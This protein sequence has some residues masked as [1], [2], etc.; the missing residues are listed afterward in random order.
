MAQTV[1]QQT[2][3]CQTKNHQLRSPRKVNFPENFHT[4]FA[5]CTQRT[6]KLLNPRRTE[7]HLKFRC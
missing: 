4:D 6:E 2:R 5:V 7:L 1:M 3:Q